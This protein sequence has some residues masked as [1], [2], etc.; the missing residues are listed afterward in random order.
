MRRPKHPVFIT[1]FARRHAGDRGARLGLASI[2]AIVESA[3]TSIP[4]RASASRISFG[5]VPGRLSRSLATSW[6]H[7]QGP[8]DD[9]R[10]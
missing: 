1:D 2:S 7:A 5:V 10:G 8:A 6:R 3:S 9:G 4:P